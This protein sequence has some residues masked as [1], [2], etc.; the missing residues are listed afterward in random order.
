MSRVLHDKLK[1]LHTLLHE[2]DKLN[3]EIDQLKSEIE[4]LIITEKL[5][6]KQ[7]VLGNRKVVYQQTHTKENFTQKY[8]AKC[9]DHYYANDP[10]EAEGI[11]N[12]FLDNRANKS[13]FNLNIS[14][15]NAKN[16]K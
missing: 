2:Q 5:V 7:F 15:I 12:F 8:I 4:Q 3:A 6:N 11:M 14:K 9:L 13:K 10:A 16:V 1:S